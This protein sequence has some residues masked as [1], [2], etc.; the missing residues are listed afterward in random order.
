[1]MLVFRDRRREAAVSGTRFWAAILVDVA[2]SAPG[3][4]LEML[5]VQRGGNIH[6]GEGK[7]KTMAILAMLIGAAE[8][9]NSMVEAW[10]SGGGFSVAGGVIGAL[11]GALLVASAIALL[12]RGPGA[13]AFAQAAAGA[14]MAVFALF[15][16]LRPI[17]SN[18]ATILGI[19][20]P[21][22]LLLFLRWTQRRGPSVPTMA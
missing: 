19:G 4:R 7:M 2:R 10:A 13:A 18:L 20:F 15:A 14:C 21:I 3:L 12:R 16:A 5:R 1:M 22:V 8:V 17:F 11:A 9:V 6:I